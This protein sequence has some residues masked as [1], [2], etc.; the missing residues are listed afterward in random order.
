MEILFFFQLLVI[1]LAMEHIHMIQRAIGEI[2]VHLRYIKIIPVRVMSFS[3]LMT[4]GIRPPGIEMQV[5]ASVLSQTNTI[6]FYLHEIQLNNNENV[7]N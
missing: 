2:I 7:S 6:T 4:V 1:V 5:I 3:F